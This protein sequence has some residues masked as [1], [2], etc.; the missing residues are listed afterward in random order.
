M[1]RACGT[2]SASLGRSGCSSPKL[3]QPLR[4]RLRADTCKQVPL[5]ATT[6]GEKILRLAAGRGFQPQLPSPYKA[7]EIISC[8]FPP[9]HGA[10]QCLRPS[11]LERHLVQ[12]ILEAEP[13]LGSCQRRASATLCQMNSCNLMYPLCSRG[14]N[15]QET[16]RWMPPWESEVSWPVI[17]VNR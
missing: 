3:A 15:C 5:H 13:E 4:W 7:P 2:C 9:S 6:Y 8:N 10:M 1:A 11:N 17:E 16:S 14:A 12:R